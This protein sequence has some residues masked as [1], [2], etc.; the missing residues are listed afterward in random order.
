MYH[1][2]VIKFRI[3]AIGL[4]FLLVLAIVMGSLPLR[5]FPVSLLTVVLAQADEKASWLVS[6]PVGTSYDVSNYSHILPIGVS[7]FVEFIPSKDKYYW[8]SD[9]VPRV[10]AVKEF[11]KII[12]AKNTINNAYNK[13]T[14]RSA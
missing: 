12:T 6:N 4:S 1:K 9:T 2:F 3:L 10:L 7:P 14:V 13:V 5:S 8:I 11:R